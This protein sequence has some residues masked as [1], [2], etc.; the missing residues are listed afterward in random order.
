[1]IRR[2]PSLFLLLC[3]APAF[4]QKRPFDIETLLRIQRIGDP[5]L[6][7]DGKQVAF[8]VAT[9]DLS[10]NSLPKQ[11]YLVSVTGGT[12]RQLTR[13]GTDNERPRWSPDSREIYFISTRGG[14]SQV[15]VM[16][17]DGTHPRPITRLATEAGGVLES[18]PTARS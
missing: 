12:P 10:T 7:P 14:S 4:A 5:A 11:I 3:T 18:R 15:W 2:L 6:S 17:A 16:D 1:M 13:E 9:P 8:T